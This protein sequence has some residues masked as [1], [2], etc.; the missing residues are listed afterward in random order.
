MHRLPS[1]DGNLEHSVGADLSICCRASE[2]ADPG[3]KT[4]Q[5]AASRGADAMQR[6]ELSV[7]P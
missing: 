1:D 7:Y 4:S 2:I 6:R 5:L 3:I